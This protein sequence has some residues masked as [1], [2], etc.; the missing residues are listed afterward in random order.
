[1]NKTFLNK[2]VN[3]VYL[4]DIFVVLFKGVIGTNGCLY[5]H[6]KEAKLN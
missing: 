6:T 5:C 3:L 2:Q 1:M 4:K